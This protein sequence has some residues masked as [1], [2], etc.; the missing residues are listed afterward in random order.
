MRHGRSS[1]PN[2]TRLVINN[3]RPTW[4][5][6]KRLRSNRVGRAVFRFFFILE[7]KRRKRVFERMKK[8]FSNDKSI[9]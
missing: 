3:G 1:M 8:E 6:L 2:L 9:Y 7:S 4:F 5:Y